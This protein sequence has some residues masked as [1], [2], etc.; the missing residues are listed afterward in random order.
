MGVFAY[1]VETA[2]TNA[3]GRITC[4]NLNGRTYNYSYD[5]KGRLTSY[6]DNQDTASN[7]AYEYDHEGRRVQ[8]TRG[9]KLCVP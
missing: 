7:A 9:D 2:T 6:T 4:R 8:M 1:V 3:A 5:A